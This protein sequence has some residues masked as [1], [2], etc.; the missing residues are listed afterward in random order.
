MDKQEL[1]AVIKYLHLK[2][3]TQE[4]F[5][6]TKGTLAESAPAYSTVTKWNAEFKRGRLLC[7]DMHPFGQPATSVNELLK[8]SI[9]LS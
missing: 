9:S 1:R 3:M 5:I 6:D 7:V 8:K 4:I 2:G